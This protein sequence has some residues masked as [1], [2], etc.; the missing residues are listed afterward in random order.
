MAKENN[1]AKTLAFLAR[2]FRENHSI[3]QL[4]KQLG[5]TPKGMHKLLKRLEQQGIIKP[6]KMANA[7]FYHINFDSDLACTAAEL[8]LFEEIQT[9]YARA[10]AK[11]MERLRP[12]LMSAILFSSILE[13]G[14]KAKDIDLLA[15]F[16]KNK[17]S[18]F[19]KKL[20]EL[21]ALK[22]KHIH[23][24]LQT[25]EDL[26]KN[27]QKPDEVILEILKKGKILWGHQIIIDAIKQAVKK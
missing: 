8:A 19:Q 26:I 3:N 6:N 24:V 11:D 21:Q 9:P 16:E 23:T 5:L 1:E 14:E 4:A 2:R 18:F 20:D 10:Q 17:Y 7:I 27:L 25:P 13:K 15:V 12:I 22:I